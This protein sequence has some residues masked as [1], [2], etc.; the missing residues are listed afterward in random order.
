MPLYD[1]ECQHCGARFD[2]ILPI[3][4]DTDEHHCP[5]C[6]NAAKKVIT[7]G[8]GGIVRTGDS[9][10]WVREATLTLGDDARNVQT[11]QDLRKYYQTHPN[12]R[13]V[14]SHS[15]FPSEYGDCMDRPDPKQVAK[16]RS[17]KGHELIR[18]MRK[19]EVAGQASV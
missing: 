13:P 16:Q 12:V 19:I 5:E 15:A 6:G 11:I 9:V 4:C 2:T 17:K 10:P 14:E 18:S 1:Y 3:S 8:H 7:L